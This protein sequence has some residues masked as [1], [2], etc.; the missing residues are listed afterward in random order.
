MPSGAPRL[1]AVLADV[2]F[3]RPA[4]MGSLIAECAMEVFSG[5]RTAA[6]AAIAVLMAVT[7]AFHAQ[8]RSS[9]PR[10]IAFLGVVFQNDNE[11]L[12]P[13]SDEERARVTALEKQFVTSLQRSGKYAVLPVAPEL[14]AKIAAGQTLGACSGCEI[15]YGKEAKAQDVAWIEVQK[16]S[17]LILNMNVYIGNVE[18]GVYDFKHSVDIRGNTDES[19]RRSLKYLLDNYLFKT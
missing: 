12:E 17:N 18:T 7:L 8:A 9:A 15:T 14:R 6:F 13:T 3:R 10:S 5:S 4:R 2:E 11:G 1:C 19:W 16:V